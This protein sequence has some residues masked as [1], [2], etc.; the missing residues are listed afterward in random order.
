[1]VA[2]SGLVYS[3]WHL[4]CQPFQLNFTLT[5]DPIYLVVPSLVAKSSSLGQTFEARSWSR[6]SA[7]WLK[8]F[9]VHCQSPLA[10]AC[11]DPFT[12]ILPVRQSSTSSRY[13][14][15]T[16]SLQRSWSFTILI[17]PE[18]NTCQACYQTCPT[19]ALFTARA[20]PDLQ[21]SPCCCCWWWWW[22]HVPALSTLPAH[23][24]TRFLSI[25]FLPL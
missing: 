11:S 17:L 20:N 2:C 5:C 4:L 21:H 19:W 1:M 12:V 24:W 13:S 15:H 14:A 22:L 6:P 8:T 3:F 23:S 9:K 7:R 18:W 10:L 16:S 25:T